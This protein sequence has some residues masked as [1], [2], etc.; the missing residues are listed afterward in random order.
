M[1]VGD[2][3][4]SLSLI[5]MSSLKKKMSREVSELNDIIDK[6]GLMNIYRTESTFVSANP[7]TFF[8]K[9][10]I[11]RHKATPKKYRKIETSHYILS[12]SNEIK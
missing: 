2:F 10:H 8:L 11:M 4:S 12:D 5:E 1:I 9:G 3:N 6:R 7:V